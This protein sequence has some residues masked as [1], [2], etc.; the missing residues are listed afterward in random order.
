MDK[1][2]GQE[3]GPKDRSTQ[4]REKRPGHQ[5]GS[6]SRPPERELDEQQDDDRY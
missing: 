5:P 4:Q 6:G 3:K 2:K 1:Q